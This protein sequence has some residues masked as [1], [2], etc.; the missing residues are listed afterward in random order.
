[1]NT[2]LPLI[3]HRGIPANLAAITAKV[4]KKIWFRMKPACLLIEGGSTAAQIVRAFAWQNL[5]PAAEYA[6]G[7]VGLRIPDDD[8][9][10]LVV[11]PGS[12]PWPD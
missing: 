11:K 3:R 2:G 7:V 5:Y 10:R 1:L 8:R 12:Y 6:R 4:V 9:L